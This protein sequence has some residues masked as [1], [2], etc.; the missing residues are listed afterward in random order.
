MQRA[1]PEH[2]FA[3]AEPP[4]GAKHKPFVIRRYSVHH[5]IPIKLF[6]SLYFLILFENYNPNQIVF[7]AFN[8]NHAPIYNIMPTVPKAHY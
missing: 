3:E 7:F 8:N 5:Y 2:G 6:N 4:K 1:K